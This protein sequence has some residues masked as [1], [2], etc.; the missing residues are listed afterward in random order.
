[1]VTEEVG[2][3]VVIQAA[4]VDAHPLHITASDQADTPALDPVPIHQ[5]VS[6]HQ[7]TGLTDIKQTLCQN[8]LPSDASV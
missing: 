2:V 4:T 3:E 7:I 6:I 5:A 8:L 1:M